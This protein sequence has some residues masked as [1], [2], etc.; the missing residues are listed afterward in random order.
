MTSRDRDRSEPTPVSISIEVVAWFNGTIH[1]NLAGIFCPREAPAINKT[2]EQNIANND[3]HRR[4][5]ADPTNE[6]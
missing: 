2:F 3:A 1:F 6:R 4:N 5:A